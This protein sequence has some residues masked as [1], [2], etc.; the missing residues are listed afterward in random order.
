MLNDLGPN[1]YI[2]QYELEQY[3][4]DIVHKQVISALGKID[5]PS[6]QERKKIKINIE[7]WNHKTFF[8]RL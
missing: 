3:T 5:Q 6:F 1:D 2:N 7:T 8:S 4:T